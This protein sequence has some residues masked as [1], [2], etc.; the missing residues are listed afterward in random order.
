MNNIEKNEKEEWLD[1]NSPSLQEAIRSMSADFN[2][3]WSGEQL[4]AYYENRKL[5]EEQQRAI[6]WDEAMKVKQWVFNQPEEHQKFIESGEVAAPI[7][8][9]KMMRIVEE[10]SPEIS[11]LP[12]DKLLQSLTDCSGDVWEAS[13]CLECNGKKTY[14]Y[15]STLQTLWAN[16]LKFN[17]KDDTF[18]LLEEMTKKKLGLIKRPWWK[19]WN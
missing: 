7:E 15:I 1:L 12:I 19:F 14:L 2:P 10:V 3:H 6:I 18:I 4:H 13:W 11:S 16:L 17:S 9:K 5:T 8:H